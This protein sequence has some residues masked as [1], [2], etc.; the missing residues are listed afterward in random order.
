M[1]VGKGAVGTPIVLAPPNDLL[2]LAITEGIENALSLYEAT[3]LGCWASGGAGRLPPLAAAVPRWI[4]T[5]TV[6]GDPE[7]VGRHNA[8]ALADA[9]QARGIHCEFRIFG[10][11]TP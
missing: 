3:G 1:T 8:R 11:V 10:Q 5:V 4:D 2:G 6:W 7:P 9:I